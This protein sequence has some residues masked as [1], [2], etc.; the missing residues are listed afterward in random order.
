MWAI[1]QH[2][3]CSWL[4]GRNHQDSLQLEDE[5]PTKGWIKSTNMTLVGNCI[6]DTWLVWSQATRCKCLLSE[7]YTD[8]VEDII[9]NKYCRLHRTGLGKHSM[10]QIFLTLSY[11]ITTLM[12]QRQTY[13]PSYHQQRR[14]EKGREKGTN[15]MSLTVPTKNIVSY[16]DRRQNTTVM[17]VWIMRTVTNI[18]YRHAKELF[19]TTYGWYT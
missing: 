8:F 13:L 10:C 4:R 15:R 16:T 18:P 11:M 1:L 12:N 6:V 7:F 14:K 2:V 5:L 9:D 17:N 19:C 3:C